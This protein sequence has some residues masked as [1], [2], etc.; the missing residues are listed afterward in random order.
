[1]KIRSHLD[2]V[3]TISL[4][5]RL[6]RVSSFSKGS[7][8]AIS[9]FAAVFLAA[10]YKVGDSIKE[11]RS[12]Y[13]NYQALKSLTTV[14]FY[15]T[16]ATYLQSGDATLLNQAQ[17]QL[18]LIV[19]KTQALNAPELSNNVESNAN[20]LKSDIDTKY[21]AMGKLSGDPLALLNNAEQGISSISASLAKYAQQSTA[22]TQAQ[23]TSYLYQTS[24]ISAALSNVIVAREKVISGSSSS[25]DG[26]NVAIEE[27]KS[28]TEKLKGLPLLAI[29]PAKDEDE[30]DFFDDEEDAEDLSEEALDELSTLVNRYQSELANTT[31]L[32]RQKE[33]GLSLLS[34]QVSVLEA[35]ILSGEKVID[36]QQAALNQQLVVV[37]IGLLAFL[38]IF[39]SANYW[40]MRSVIL[41]PLRKLRDSFVLLVQEGKVENIKGISPK[42]ELGEISTSFNQLVN[43]LAEEDKE[44]AN[45]LN[46]VS[47]AMQTMESQARN[48]LDSSNT[49]HQ[50]LG[51]VDD[52]MQ[53]LTQVTDTVNT[54]SQQVVDNAQA[55]QVAMN[56]SQEKVTEV[57]SASEATN[58]AASDGKQ[59]IIS[60]TQSV[61]SVGS[62]VDVISSIADQTNLLALN[63][64]IEAARAGEHGRGFSVVADEVRQLAGKTQE[65]LGQVSQR[66]E[67]LNQASNALE[68]NIFG[69]EAASTQQRSIAEVLKDNAANVVQQA[70]TSANVAEETLGQINQ[71]RN[72]FA[73][74]ANAMQSVNGEVTQSKDLAE[75]ISK[76]VSDQ[77]SDINQT[78]NL[79]S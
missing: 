63:A 12:Q 8:I 60:L 6:M 42:T 16:I 28:E 2:N 69:I 62:I 73:E 7:V 13:A 5:G 76:D 70:I 67:Q 52:I 23:R 24:L 30:D 35:I 72:H 54:L 55:T 15:R 14:G 47:N 48:I 38:I 37:V 11:G 20:T 66:L 22:I 59:A 64:A 57:L 74:F 45:Q 29:F 46:L 10:M 34:E 51:E 61:E 68:K 19:T 39:L 33:Q 1:V 25:I 49:T 4:E 27:L 26:V 58:Q 78:L 75:N 53:A 3:C 65:S 50:H 43:K 79:V 36:E 17:E 71:Q 44:K 41:K 31:S 56:H 40:L 21:R 32:M 9:I 18:D 77:M